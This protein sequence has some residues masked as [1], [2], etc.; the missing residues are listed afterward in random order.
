MDKMSVF[1]FTEQGQSHIDKGK[2]CQDASGGREYSDEGVY[3][4]VVSDGHGGENYF[5]SDR[6][7]KL[8][9]SITLEAIHSFVENA[10]KALL[11]VPYTATPALSTE[12]K[13]GSNRKETEQDRSLR[14]LFSYIISCWNDRIEE[15][16]KKNPPAEEETKKVPDQV[17]TAF[18]KNQNLEKAYGCTL[19]AFVRTPDYWFAFHIGD[20]K[21]VAFYEN[22]EWDEPIP[23]DEQCFL[24]Y[25]TSMCDEK[26]LD[27]FRYCYGMDHIPLAVFLGS[28]GIDDSFGTIENL[29][30]FYG[31]M[32]KMFV[33]EGYDQS[34][35]EIPPYLRKLTAQ[36]SR[37]DM[38]VAGVLD[39]E[40]IRKM[41]P[42]LIEKE[43]EQ[44]QQKL[45][46]T[47]QKRKRSEEL[48]R[49]KKEE[50]EKSSSN[51]DILK[52]EI[53]HE[54]DTVSNSIV[55]KR[56]LEQEL[57]ERKI[58]RQKLDTEI[59]YAES[60]MNQAVREQTGIMENLERLDQELI[61][62]KTGQL[63]PFR[64]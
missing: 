32:L 35:S 44:L 4:C 37:D 15:D 29:A 3:M 63:E 21:C 16:W 25:T 41:V 48:L 5:R 30:G 20:G 47:E 27:N 18:S 54:E 55:T 39:L 8:A 42:S 60:D 17:K 53:Q 58:R 59:K 6:G 51:E 45:E 50:L 56:S 36:G 34:V 14:H 52:A 24:N 2:V 28:D 31:L 1:A 26:A 61:E 7:A 11:A 49:E 19:M 13:G 23:W 10:D 62:F 64:D 12:M 46:N 9:V 33:K 38:S 57:N 43:K 40:G 22:G